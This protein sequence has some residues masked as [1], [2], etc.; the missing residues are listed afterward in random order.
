[1]QLKDSKN[2]QNFMIKSNLKL[3]IL[4]NNFSLEKKI[5]VLKKNEKNLF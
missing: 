5:I 2:F 4:V 3:L 1:M